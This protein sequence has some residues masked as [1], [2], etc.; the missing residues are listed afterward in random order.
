[1]FNILDKIIHLSELNIHFCK[2]EINEASL[3]ILEKVLKERNNLETIYLSPACDSPV[4]LNRF[5]RLIFGS[6]SLS[7]VNLLG[8]N[9][10]ECSDEVIS[11]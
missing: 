4:T 1:M 9:F 10:H 7:V 3:D 6:S 11:C 8:I 5:L 2:V